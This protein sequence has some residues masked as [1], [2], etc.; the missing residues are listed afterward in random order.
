MALTDYT[1]YDAIRAVL[2]TTEDELEDGTLALEMY[3]TYLR[4]EFEDIHLNIPAEYVTVAGIQEATRTVAQQRFY[5]VSRL[6]AAY[7]VAH[8][9]RTSLPMFGPKDV[10]DGKAT[11]GRFADSPYKV[12]LENVRKEYDRLKT[13]L[14]TAFA[15][16]SASSTTTPTRNLFGIS[17]PATD[18][19]TGS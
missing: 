17:S 16:L 15:A 11:T 19:V 9:L 8:Q 2:G 14:G 1:T 4:M 3:S 5:E 10:S 18:P 13:R 12:T 6:F 7:A